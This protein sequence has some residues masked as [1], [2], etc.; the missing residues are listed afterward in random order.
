MQK[1]IFFALGILILFTP[2]LYASDSL[3]TIAVMDFKNNSLFEKEKQE[4]LAK[5]LAE[6]LITELSQVQEIQVVERQQLNAIIEEM[7]LAQTGLLSEN[8]SIEVGKLLGAK[9]LVLGSFMAVPG[10]TIR[11]DA[12][13]VEVETGKTL[14]GEKAQGKDKEILKIINKLSQA[15]LT[16]LELSITRARLTQVENTSPDA[17]FALSKGLEFEDTGNRKMAL[18]WYKIALSKD[19][20][21]LVAQKRIQKLAEVKD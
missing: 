18:H 10:N 5:G 21:L 9:F 16:R 11:V 7:Q 8:T 13:I 12:R 17:I 2:I 20:N 3:T 4:S 15:I 6:I 1:I 14:M 19:K